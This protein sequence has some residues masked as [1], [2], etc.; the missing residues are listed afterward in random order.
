MQYLPEGQRFGKVLC[1]CMQ[2]SIDSHPTYLFH[3]T[4]KLRSGV[5]AKGLAPML[6]MT[7]FVFVSTLVPLSGSL[8]HVCSLGGGGWP[9]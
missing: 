5:L 8:E 2:M 1:L 4:P 9:I 6:M 3:L 7:Q